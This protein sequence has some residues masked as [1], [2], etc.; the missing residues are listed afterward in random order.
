MIRFAYLAPEGQ[1]K[2]IEAEERIYT[3]LAS[4]DDQITVDK[5][6]LVLV[7]DAIRIER[8]RAVTA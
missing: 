8:A 6:D 4:T 5:A 1:A 3:A 2:C 7:L